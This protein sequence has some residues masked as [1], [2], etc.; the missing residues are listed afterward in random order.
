MTY[1]EILFHHMGDLRQGTIRTHR[2]ASSAMALS[3]ASPRSSIAENLSITTLGDFLDVLYASAVEFARLPEAL[4]LFARA[5]DAE[6]AYFFTLDS[7]SAPDR[8]TV[9][10]RATYAGGIATDREGAAAATGQLLVQELAAQFSHDGAEY[11]RGSVGLRQANADARRL[12]PAQP[13]AIHYLALVLRVEGE[14]TVGILA[15]R[16]SHPFTDA[17][18]Q[19]ICTLQPDIR[20]ALDLRR[21]AGRAEALGLGVQLFDRNPTAILITRQRSIERSN[22]AA[23]ALLAEGRPV[24]LVSG[25]LCF[26]DARANSAFE[27]ISRPDAQAQGNHA[28]AFVVE[29]KGGSTWIAQLSSVRPSPSASS[30]AA[31][32]ASA[33]VAALTPFNFASHTRE[34]MLNGFTDL[35]PTER[36]IFA[37]FVDGQDIPAIAARLKRSIETVRWHVRNLFTKLGV[38]SQAD[39]ARLGA[40]LLP[41]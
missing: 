39:L 38:N 28:F 33:V 19:R 13:G 32:N 23:L 30:V 41:I 7:A 17:E 3:Y 1:A 25:K 21:R 15:A 37:A 34:A 2:S 6:D 24:S 10:E 31:G 22:A 20:R 18:R 35:T 40:L 16:H 14:P 5:F 8:A 26:E 4:T 27:L 29:G 36:T 11:F 12:I 9:V